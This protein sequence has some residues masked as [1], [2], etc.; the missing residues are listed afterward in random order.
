VRLL[1]I[2]VD[3][4]VPSAIGTLTA[5][6][7]WEDHV[8]VFGLLN[9]AFFQERVHAMCSVLINGHG[10][11][12]R[13]NRMIE[14]R[15]CD[16]FLTYWGPPH[17]SA[18]FELKFVKGKHGKPVSEAAAHAGLREAVEQVD[19]AFGTRAL[20][21]VGV[22]VVFTVS[23]ASLKGV[24]V[25]EVVPAN[26][27]KYPLASREGKTIHRV[28]V[29]VHTKARPP[30]DVPDQGKGRGGR[31]SER[32]GRKRGS[33]GGGEDDEEEDEEDE[34]DEEVEEEDEDEEEEA[35]V[36]KSR[37]GRGSEHA[38]QKRPRD[39]G[40]AVHSRDKRARKDKGSKGKR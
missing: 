7:S 39:R 15:I 9:E 13:E 29:R 6:R 10:Q 14:R 23:A 24:K 18:V 2:A 25:F 40:G 12:V 17:S 30:A 20:L 19:H 4:G 11:C 35:P 26:Y 16:E 1:K 28:I 5:K 33:R 36:G 22:A 27:P 31:G 34:E 3:E 37:G 38:G 21:S 32:A 8:K